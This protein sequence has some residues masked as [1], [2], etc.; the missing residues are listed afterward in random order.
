MNILIIFLIF[1]IV[2]ESVQS[3]LHTVLTL[4]NIIW[5]N[6]IDTLLRSITS[7]PIS[8]PHQNCR[9]IVVGI[10]CTFRFGCRYLG[11]ILFI[12]KDAFEILSLFI[13]EHLLVGKCGI[14]AFNNR[15]TSIL[16]HWRTIF[17]IWFN[18]SRF[19][20]HFIEWRS[21][22]LLCMMLF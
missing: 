1:I 11:L 15:N 19:T 16:I 21:F 17:L 13:L 7:E 3:I 18:N 14:I 8:S 10:E 9:C 20:M 6:H 12:I 2:I 4:L 22:C 5:R